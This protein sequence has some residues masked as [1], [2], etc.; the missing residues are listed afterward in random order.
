MLKAH[1]RKPDQPKTALN[2][3]YGPGNGKYDTH[4]EIS[5]HI[6]L[7]EAIADNLSDRFVWRV[8]ISLEMQACG[9]ANARW[10]IARSAWSSATS[11][12]TSSRSSIASTDARWRFRSTRKSRSRRRRAAEVGRR[13]E[14]EVAP[15]QAGGAIAAAPC[16][17]PY[18]RSVSS[19]PMRRGR[20]PSW[21]QRCMRSCQPPPSMPPPRPIRCAKVSRAFCSSLSEL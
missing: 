13:P 20:P 12:P 17:A 6:R 21:R 4:A 10:T 7:L 14:A 8:P 9:E 1:L 3:V 18:S 19:P 2:I 16:E 15:R 11:S 5:R